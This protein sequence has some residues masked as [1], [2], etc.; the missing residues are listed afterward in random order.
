MLAQMHNVDLESNF[1]DFEYSHTL[2]HIEV[3]HL[4]GTTLYTQI[5]S[6][7]QSSSI[8]T[9]VT[10]SLITSTLLILSKI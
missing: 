3:Q 10:L 1:Q 6:Q 8:V 4:A 9:R 7:R 2:D 5:F